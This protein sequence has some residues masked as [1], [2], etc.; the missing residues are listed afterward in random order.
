MC[1]RLHTDNNCKPRQT[2]FTLMTDIYFQSIITTN[3]QISHIGIKVDQP[4]IPRET[5]ILIYEWIPPYCFVYF[6]VHQIHWSQTILQRIPRT[7]CL[8]L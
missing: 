8:N 1:I 3:L 5:Y 2:R 7:A 6:P 4:P